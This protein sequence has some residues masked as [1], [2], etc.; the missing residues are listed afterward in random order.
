MAV[1]WSLPKV[2]VSTPPV[3]VKVA[4]VWLPDCSAD[5][6]TVKPALTVSNPKTSRLHAVPWRCTVREAPVKSVPRSTSLTARAPPVSRRA[7]PPTPGQATLSPSRPV[8][9]GSSLTGVTVTE[10][11][12]V[13]AEKAVMP[14]LVVVSAVPPAVPLV[15]SHAL[16]VMVA[17]PL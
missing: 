3:L 5:P 4:K 6:L 10:A 7:L 15:L 12:S 13:A 8:I 11:V 1:V 9:T 2:I 16:K 14:P 17:V